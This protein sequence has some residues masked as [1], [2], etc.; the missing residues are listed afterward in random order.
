MAEKPKKK[1][2]SKPI[3]ASKTFKKT[4][5]GLPKDVRQDLSRQFAELMKKVESAQ[6]K[7]NAQS[8]L[9]DFTDEVLQAELDRRK[10]AQN[11]EIQAE[12]IKTKRKAKK[13]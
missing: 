2:E 8:Y 6:K 13:K 5:R 9:S 7:V 1:Q 11:V 4:L 12:T 3:V 10:N